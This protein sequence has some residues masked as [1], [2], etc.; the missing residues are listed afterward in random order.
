V[1]CRGWSSSVALL[2]AGALSLSAG[3]AR[4]A[5]VRLAISGYDP[6]AYFTDHKPVPGDSK[7]EYQWHNLRWRFANLA[8]RVLFEHDPDHYAPQYDGYCAVGVEVHPP[9][10]DTVDPKAWA[11]VDGKLY[12]THNRHWLGVWRKDTADN[13][14]RGHENWPSVEKQTVLYDG[15]PHVL[16][17]PQS[18]PAAPRPAAPATHG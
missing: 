8:H 11:I 7:F 12:L 9:H 6:V 15:Y 16:G 17:T 14:R 4:S 3:P 13:I 5:E 18:T 2:L 1:A 10:K